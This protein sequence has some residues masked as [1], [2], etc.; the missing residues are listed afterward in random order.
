MHVSGY[1]TVPQGI[2]SAL[3]DDTF[4]NYIGRNVKIL[5]HRADVVSLL[6]LM[7]LYMHCFCC[8]RD[9]CVVSV[10][11]LTFVERV[12]FSKHK[13]SF[14]LPAD[15]NT[16]GRLLLILDVGAKAGLNKDAFH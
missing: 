3:S 15:D 5:G 2:I 1:D 10:R 8:V 16:I 6:E 11:H 7:L 9:C 13:L 12:A 14:S 4:H